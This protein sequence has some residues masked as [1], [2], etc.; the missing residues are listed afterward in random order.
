MRRSRAC[1]RA[2]KPPFASGFPRTVRKPLTPELSS[3]R[4]APCL[5]TVPPRDRNAEPDMKAS[6]CCRHYPAI[7]RGWRKKRNRAREHEAQPHDGNDAHG[8]RSAGENTGAVEEEPHSRDHLDQS[9][10]VK[11]ER[12]QRADHERR[13]KAEE[14]LTSGA[15]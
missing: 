4:A 5:A 11:D 8:E 7:P 10:A 14:K 1:G 3:S 6:K 13:R 2:D 12:Q 9:T 15:R